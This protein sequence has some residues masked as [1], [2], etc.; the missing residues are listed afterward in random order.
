MCGSEDLCGLK[1]YTFTCGL[2]TD[3]QPLGHGRRYCYETFEEARDTLAAWSG[4]EHPSGP[5]FKCKGATIDLL[6]P[7]FG[8][9]LRGA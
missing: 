2:V 6:N 8:L 9:E 3:I 1:H 4:K 5:W 7:V